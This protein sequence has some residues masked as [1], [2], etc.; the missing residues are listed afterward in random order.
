MLRKDMSTLF[1]KAHAFQNEERLLGWPVSEFAEL[2]RIE[3]SMKPFIKMWMSA[4]NF[5]ESHREWL[6]ANVLD[7]NMVS[8]KQ[9]VSTMICSNATRCRQIRSRVPSAAFVCIDPEG[10]DL[11]T[12]PTEASHWNSQRQK[13]KNAKQHLSFRSSN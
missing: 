12:I 3:E 6:H 7:L 10:K 9:S 8:T 11:K 2:V 5:K 1:N 4:K 13:D